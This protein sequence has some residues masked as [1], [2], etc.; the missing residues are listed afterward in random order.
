MKLHATRSRAEAEAE[1]QR[2]LRSGNRPPGWWSRLVNSQRAVG[3]LALV[4]AVGCAGYATRTAL[5]DAALS[6]RGVVT[7][8]RIV[9]VHHSWGRFDSSYVVVDLDT[10]HGT[11]PGI[12]VDDWDWHPSPHVGDDVRVRYDP[13]NPEVAQ[14]ARRGPDTVT[15]LWW[16]AFAILSAVAGIAGLRRRLPAWLLRR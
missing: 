11:V 2:R 5:D 1:R 3:V 4:L 10:A 7:S 9:A 8:A 16:G 12:K 6:R 15:V 14:D 13:Q